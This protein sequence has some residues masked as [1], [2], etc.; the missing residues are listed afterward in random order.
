MLRATLVAGVAAG[1]SACANEPQ[2]PR[3]AL[4]P[5]ML[6]GG[7][8]TQVAMQPDAVQTP[9]ADAVA[10]LDV[11]R[12]SMAAKVLTARALEIV[13]GLKPDPARLSEHD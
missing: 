10:S 9:R 7:P 6:M 8:A 1:V 5:M 3:A 11:G 13:T 2:L 12:K 4:P